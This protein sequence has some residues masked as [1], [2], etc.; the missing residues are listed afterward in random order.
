MSNLSRVFGSGREPATLLPY[1]PDSLE[2]L[3]ARWVR[4]V[5]GVGPLRNPVADTTG[6]DAG[7]DQ[8]GDVWFLA[9]TFGGEAERR[10]TVPA[11][12]PLFFPVFNMWH[13]QAAGP[14]PHLPRAFGTLAVDGGPVEVDMIATPMP[15]KVAGA[16]MNPVTGSRKP[17][18]MTVWGF[19]KRL[20]PLPAGQHTLRFAGGDGYGFT[21]T[22]TYQ[23]IVA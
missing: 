11:G 13:L 10:C 22:I 9:G 1:R 20:D 8:P 6:A 14:P 18:A 3:A 12:R 16:R 7:V 5:A 23:L 4:W 19:W 15:F 2:G 17:V 21:V